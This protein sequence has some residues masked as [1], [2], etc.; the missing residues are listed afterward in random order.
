[1][2][3]F[4]NSG[5]GKVRCLPQVFEGSHLFMC[6]IN[7]KTSG[8][9]RPFFYILSCLGSNGFQWDPSPLVPH[10]IETYAGIEP[11][12]LDKATHC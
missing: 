4:Q 5:V 12:M 10:G 2:G 3:S 7:S 9:E 11:S 6:R 8:T 1:M